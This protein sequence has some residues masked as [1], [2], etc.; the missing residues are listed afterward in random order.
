MNHGGQNDTVK[1]KILYTVMAVGA[2]RDGA[3]PSFCIPCTRHF[4][5]LPDDLF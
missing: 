4:G 5:K 1:E 3:S 2:L